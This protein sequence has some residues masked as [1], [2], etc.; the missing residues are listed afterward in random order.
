[1]QLIDVVDESK[2]VT[3]YDKYKRK[4]ERYPGEEMYLGDLMKII[5]QL[6]VQLKLKAGCL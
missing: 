3:E 5:T 2:L 6:E 4:V 1:M